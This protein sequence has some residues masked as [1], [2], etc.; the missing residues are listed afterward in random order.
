MKKILSI[1]FGG[2]VILASIFAMLA[3]VSSVSTGLGFTTEIAI[4]TTSVVKTFGVAGVA[5]TLV[6]SSTLY[7]VLS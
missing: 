3:L 5:I 1:L 6:L 2:A 4:I 7:W